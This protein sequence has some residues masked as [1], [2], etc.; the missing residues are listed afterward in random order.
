MSLMIFALS[1]IAMIPLAIFYIFIGASMNRFILSL[2][3]AL[4]G[5]GQDA[6]MYHFVFMLGGI[7]ISAASI[8]YISHVVKKEL[9]KVSN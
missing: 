5:R 7:F 6:E 4:K 3:E 1:N 9:N 2:N 8:S